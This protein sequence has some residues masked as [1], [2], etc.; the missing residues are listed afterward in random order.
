MDWS[1][2]WRLGGRVGLASF[3]AVRYS[4]WTDLI[5]IFHQGAPAVINTFIGS[6]SNCPQLPT[7]LPNTIHSLHRIGLDLLLILVGS[8]LVPLAL[9]LSFPFIK[10]GH[11]GVFRPLKYYIQNSWGLGMS[12][13]P[14]L[15]SLSVLYFILVSIKLWLS[16]IK[17]AVDWGR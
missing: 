3:K 8:E 12:F 2:F 6:P 1:S 10:D 17:T 16:N 9:G 13:C 4:L 15:L 7:S 11:R 5:Q 14:P